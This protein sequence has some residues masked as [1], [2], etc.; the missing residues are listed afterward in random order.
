MFV[1]LS[2]AL[3]LA[4]IGF[5]LFFVSVLRCEHQGRILLEEINSCEEKVKAAKTN[6]I[7]TMNQ[8]F[9][10]EV[11]SEEKPSMWRLF[12]SKQPKKVENKN[13]DLL[14]NLQNFLGKFQNDGQ[15][16]LALLK[17]QTAIKEYEEAETAYMLAIGE[18]NSFL[19]K[20]GNKIAVKCLDFKEKEYNRASMLGLTNNETMKVVLDYLKGKET[21]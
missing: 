5:I 18:W 12:F 3:G 16:R 6:Y 2:I 11:I 10:V 17:I 13:A 4:L 8:S 20:K 9:C 7:Q 1:I 21:Y 19:S 15:M 14:N